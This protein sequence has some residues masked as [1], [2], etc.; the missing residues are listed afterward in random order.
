MQALAAL[1][2]IDH[3]IEERFGDNCDLAFVRIDVTLPS[4]ECRRK[5]ANCKGKTVA[6]QYGVG[7]KEVPKLVLYKNRMPNVYDG[8][9]DLTDTDQVNSIF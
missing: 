6:E 2:E 4:H 3:E 8:K 5:D 9:G 7:A 1:E